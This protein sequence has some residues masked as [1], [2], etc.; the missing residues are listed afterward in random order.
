MQDPG[1]AGGYPGEGSGAL[2]AA[3]Q[4]LLGAR[5]HKRGTRAGVGARPPPA[6]V[7]H[8]TLDHLFIPNQGY[9]YLH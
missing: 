3:H 1:K 6:T 8:K 9:I 5:Q 7:P 4:V 2:P